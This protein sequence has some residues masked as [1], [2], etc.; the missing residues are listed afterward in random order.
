ML[1]TQPIST[2]YQN[3]KTRTTI[4]RTPFSDHNIKHYKHISSTAAMLKYCTLK[5]LHLPII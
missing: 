1:S 2:Q 3:Q 5:I 4:K